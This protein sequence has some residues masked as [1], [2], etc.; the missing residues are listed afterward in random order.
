M[1]TWTYINDP[2]NSGEY[3]M[4]KDAD[5]LAKYLNEQ[6]KPV[7][8]IISGMLPLSHLGDFRMRQMHCILM[9]AVLM[10]LQSFRE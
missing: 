2:P 9:C 4:T 1:T 8:R 6:N 3:N 10:V 5:I 7:F